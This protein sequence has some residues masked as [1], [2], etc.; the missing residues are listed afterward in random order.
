MRTIPGSYPHYG[1]RGWDFLLLNHTALEYGLTDRIDI[2]NRL[3]TYVKLAA[4]SSDYFEPMSRR[5]FTFSL[6]VNFKI[7]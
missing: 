2:G 3:D 4:Y 7:I 1:A 5:I 6:Y